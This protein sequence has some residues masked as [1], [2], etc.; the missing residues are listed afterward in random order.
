MKDHLQQ[1]NICMTTS[2]KLALLAKLSHVIGASF[3]L[4]LLGFGFT[5]GALMSY[6]F[7]SSLGTAIAGI[8]II[9]IAFTLRFYAAHHIRR[10][11]K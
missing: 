9:A 3:F 2:A 7:S 4:F 10:Y 5:L 6:L 1:G 11:S 8:I